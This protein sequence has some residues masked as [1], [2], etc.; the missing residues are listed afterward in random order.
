MKCEELSSFE[1]EVLIHLERYHSRPRYF[2][3]IVLNISESSLYRYR[4]NILNK[5]GARN[6]SQA[7]RKAF[8]KGFLTIGPEGHYEAVEDFLLAWELSPSPLPPWD[9]LTPREIEL[10]QL[11]G[12]EQT[13]ELTNFGL[14]RRL[15]IAESTVKKHLQRM[16]RKL[17]VTTR[18]G[19]TLLAAKARLYSQRPQTT[20][21]GA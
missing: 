5:L 1:R 19:A 16:Y 18:H 13:T 3:A 8:L 12:D 6:T 21:G 2:I 9:N 14:A 15:G 4:R 20:A 11:L 17:N 10:F 7:V